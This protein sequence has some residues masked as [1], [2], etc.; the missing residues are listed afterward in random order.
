M[1]PG[2]KFIDVYGSVFS[3]DKKVRRWRQVKVNQEG[4]VRAMDPISGEWTLCHSI[5]EKHLSEI[6]THAQNCQRTFSTLK[7]S[8]ESG[9]LSLS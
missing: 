1:K 3:S 9:Q 6:R 7:L 2:N 4:E 8:K 5:S